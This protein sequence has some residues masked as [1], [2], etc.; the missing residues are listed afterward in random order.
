MMAATRKVSNH[1]FAAGAAS[2][3][4]ITGHVTTHHRA[5]SCKVSG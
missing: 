1:S 3:F 2:Q 4:P 5:S